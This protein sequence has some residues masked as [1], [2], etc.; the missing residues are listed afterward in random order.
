MACPLNIFPKKSFPE[1]R[2][3]VSMP[4][5]SQRPKPDKHKT[6]TPTL[7]GS[8]LCSSTKNYLQ[9]IALQ[10]KTLERT[11]CHLLPNPF[12]PSST[13]STVETGESYHNNHADPNLKRE[14]LSVER[15]ANVD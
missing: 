13:K 9:Q 14:A 12:E 11:P 10:H 8:R 3:T 5:V 6:L 15:T 2:L 7:D 4:F 1:T